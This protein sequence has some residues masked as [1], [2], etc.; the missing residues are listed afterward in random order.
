MWWQKY[1][2]IMC[3]MTLIAVNW[4]NQNTCIC[5]FK[6]KAFQ[7][8]YWEV[9]LDSLVSCACL[10]SCFSF[11]PWH[12]DD[13][14]L[15]IPSLL[16]HSASVFLV[17]FKACNIRPTISGIESQFL[18]PNPTE[19]LALFHSRYVQ[20]LK[21]YYTLFF[22]LTWAKCSLSIWN[23]LGVDT[24]RPG[25]VTDDFTCNLHSPISRFESIERH[26]G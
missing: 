19:W 8:Y 4:M 9:E 10:T 17:S 11:K 5:Y 20:P 2:T 1:A 16:W 25:S 13:E 23:V 18:I 3:F 15:Q 21:V 6:L 24:R 26:I 22:I 12:R 14:T 7:S